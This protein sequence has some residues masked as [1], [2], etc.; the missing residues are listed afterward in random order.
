MHS[1]RPPVGPVGIDVERPRGTLSY[2]LVADEYGRAGDELAH[3]VLALAAERA[4]ERILGI[5]SADLA[6]SWLSR[7][8]RTAFC[9]LFP[10][11]AAAYALPPLRNRCI[12]RGFPPGPAAP[13]G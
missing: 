13:G 5:A 6:H 11:R 1:R 7:R 4:I 12:D 9:P 2:A 10:A 3:L 8:P